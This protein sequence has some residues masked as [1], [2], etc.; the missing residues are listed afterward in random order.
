[1]S[2]S[3]TAQCPYCQSTFHLNTDQFQA[4]G[5]KVRCGKCFEPFL[6]DIAET[7]GKRVETE[8]LLLLDIAPGSLID[9]EWASGIKI[10][11]LEEQ[12]SASANPANKLLIAGLLL[13]IPLQLLWFNSCSYYRQ[14]ALHKL[15]KWLPLSLGCTRARQIDH[16]YLGLH[17]TKVASNKNSADTL[18]IE[19]LLSNRASYDISYPAL[20]LAFFSDRG[21]TIAR[22]VFC[23]Y[24]YLAGE[25]Y[26]QFDMPAGSEVHLAFS[27][28]DPG[29]IANRYQ[30]SITEMPCHS[31]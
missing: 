9:S 16:S 29:L 30:L 7:T 6:I 31:K 18:S 12:S 14:P 17:Q 24:E 23:P 28:I 4:A 20:S 21:S 26:G 10:N 19:T 25:A 2:E 8:E 15:I 22:R 27:I 5:G 1:M 13:L 3:L 11:P